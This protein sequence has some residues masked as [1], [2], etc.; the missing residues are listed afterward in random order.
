MWQSCQV[1]PSRFCA[2]DRT[3]SGY[4]T[5]HVHGYGELATDIAYGVATVHILLYLAP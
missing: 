5:R 2:D 3:F 4:R 1:D